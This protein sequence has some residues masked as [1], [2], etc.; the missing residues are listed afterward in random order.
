MTITC[1]TFYEKHELEHIICNLKAIY[2]GEW[3]WHVLE[4][5][6]VA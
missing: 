3:S 5:S 6:Q 1:S 2:P 4:N